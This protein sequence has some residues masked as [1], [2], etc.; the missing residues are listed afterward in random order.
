MRIKTQQ[1][2]YPLYINLEMD[3]GGPVSPESLELLKEFE[4]MIRE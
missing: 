1:N 2:K 4:T 3:E